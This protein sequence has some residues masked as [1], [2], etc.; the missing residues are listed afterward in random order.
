MFSEFYFYL[1]AV[2]DDS[3][4]KKIIY[5]E[6]CE[7]LPTV[8]RIDR[9]KNCKLT[10]MRFKVPYENRFEEG[11]FRQRVQFMYSGKLHKVKFWFRGPSLEAILDRIPTAKVLE[12][13]E[14]GYLITAEAYGEGME[15]WLK[16]QGNNVE[17]TD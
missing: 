5:K 6:G 11:I 1:I 8:Y 3:S 17:F 4:T 16:S 12:H 7:Q 2:I 10:D 15:M 9:I 13:S 14:K